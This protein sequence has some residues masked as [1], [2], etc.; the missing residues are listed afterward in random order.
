MV[1]FHSYVKLPEGK[2]NPSYEN[3]KT[4]AIFLNATK[5]SYFFRVKS[6]DMGMVFFMAE[7]EV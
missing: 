5:R 1:I 6:L 7:N 3:W 2:L 4:L